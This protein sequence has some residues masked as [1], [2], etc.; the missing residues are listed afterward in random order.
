[1]IVSIIPGHHI[2]QA[3][4][5]YKWLPTPPGH[6]QIFSSRSDLFRLMAG[7]MRFSKLPVKWLHVSCTLK[8]LEYNI[9]HPASVSMRAVARIV[10]LPPLPVCGPREDFLGL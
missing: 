3:L 9:V 6:Q 7:K 4:R 2:G 5:M 8:F 10:M 1:M